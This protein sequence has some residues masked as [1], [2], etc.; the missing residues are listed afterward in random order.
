MAKAAVEM[1]RATVQASLQ[2]TVGADCP[3]A[4]GCRRQQEQL[5]AARQALGELVLEQLRLEHEQGRLSAE[6]YEN[7]KRK[8]LES[9]L[10]TPKPASTPVR[11]PPPA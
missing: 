6:D 4:R 3:G 10:A 2:E 11:R 7:A 1:A 9:E 5:R 8:V